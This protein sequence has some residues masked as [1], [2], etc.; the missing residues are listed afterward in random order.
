MV[1]LAIRV[2]AAGL[3]GNFA[4]STAQALL[5]M[6]GAGAVLF[7]T[8]AVLSGKSENEIRWWTAFGSAVGLGLMILFVLVDLVTEGR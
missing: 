6:A 3:L 7:R 8:W 5:A 4:L 2:S 1:S